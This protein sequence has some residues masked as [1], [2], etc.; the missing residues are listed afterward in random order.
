MVCELQ[1]I[2][3][4]DAVP[5]ELR[6]PRHALVLFKKLRRISALAV[7]LTIAVR[8]SA[9]DVL[10]PLPATAATA[11]A[12]TII[13]QMPTSL[14]KKKLPLWPQALAGRRPGKS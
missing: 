4:L 13:D 3:G 7:V 14:T 2:F 12:L 9:T 8:P 6:I 5:G 1:V 10:G 11:A